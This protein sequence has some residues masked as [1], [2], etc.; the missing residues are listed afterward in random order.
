M[1]CTYRMSR[2]FAALAAVSLLVGCGASQSSPSAAAPSAEGAAY[3]LATEFARANDQ[4][5]G[6]V[7]AVSGF[8]AFPEGGVTFDGE[9]N[10][11]ADILSSA[12]GPSGEARF[13]IQMVK[14]RTTPWQVTAFQ[15]E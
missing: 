14:S 15:V 6:K 1:L 7:G 12:Y 5:T 4:L 2:A 11:Q 10:G 9:L 8:S 3:R 13:R